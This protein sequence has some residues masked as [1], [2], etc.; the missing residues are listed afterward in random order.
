MMLITEF[1]AHL[2]R[3]FE[4]DAGAISADGM[5]MLPKDAIDTRLREEA[6]KVLAWEDIRDEEKGLDHNQEQQLKENLKKCESNL[7]ASVWNAYKY[8]ALLGKDNKIRVIDFG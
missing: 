7:K 1:S 5:I 2:V 8:V 6:R 4:W 3:R